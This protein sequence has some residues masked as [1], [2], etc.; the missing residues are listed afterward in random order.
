MQ[1]LEPFAAYLAVSTDCL[2]AIFWAVDY[3]PRMRITGIAS[4]L[5]RPAP[6]IT[7]QELSLLDSPTLESSDHATVAAAA[8]AGAC[9][10]LLSSCPPSASVDDGNRTTAGSAAFPFTSASIVQQIAMLAPGSMATIDLPEAVSCCRDALLALHAA[11]TAA[12]GGPDCIFRPLKV[13]YHS[14][15]AAAVE[16]GQSI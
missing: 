2:T 4:A 11:C 7:S 9:D 14:G 5:I 8:L 15:G 12:T 1:Q 16:E 10:I 6:P 3:R 13:K